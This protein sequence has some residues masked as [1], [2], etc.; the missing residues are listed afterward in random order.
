MINISRKKSQKVIKNYLQIS[1]KRDILKT[2]KKGGD[3]MLSKEPPVKKIL[4]KKFLKPKTKLRKERLKR[5]L[6]TAYMANLIGLERRQYE[7]K[8]KGEYPFHDY[9]MYIIATAFKENEKDL[10]F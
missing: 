4:R 9:E 6:T 8:E 2:V 5:E 7:M 10:F 3:K 1:Q